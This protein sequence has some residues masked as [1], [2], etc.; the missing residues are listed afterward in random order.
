MPVNIPAHCLTPM[1]A[2]IFNS[3]S[4]YYREQARSRSH[5]VCPSDGKSIR[6]DVA[7]EQISRLMS[8]IVLPE[9]WMDRVLAQVH[10]KHEVELVRKERE[11]T[12]QRL[13]RLGRAYIDGLLVKMDYQREKQ[14]LHD[15]LASLVVP[16]LA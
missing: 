8:A 15:K 11:Q 1:W 6:R 2:Q 3:G 10:L 9:A 13:K 14:L 5:A 7:D 16:G 4:P 12:E